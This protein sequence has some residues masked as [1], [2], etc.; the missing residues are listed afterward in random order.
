MIDR[1]TAAQRL[2]AARESF[3]FSSGAYGLLM[4]EPSRSQLATIQINVLDDGTLSVTDV[5]YQLAQGTCYH[6]GFNSSLSEQSARQVV[7]YTFR[8]MV[9]QSFEVT[10]EY[11][12]SNNLSV[13]NEPW[14]QFARHYRN[15]IAHNGHWN[16]RGNSGLPLTWRN[17]TLDISMNGAPIDGFLSWFEGL[18]LCAQLLNFVSAD[19]R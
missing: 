17:R 2:N 19:I 1:D 10:K 15:A 12:T 4:T 16:M 13:A 8:Q 14:Y 6:I 9:L 18:Q 3:W 5:N 7:E 11:V